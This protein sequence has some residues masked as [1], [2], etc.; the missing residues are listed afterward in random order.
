VISG[1][2]IKMTSAFLKTNGVTLHYHFAT[3]ESVSR[4]VV[5]VNTLGTDFRI[6]QN[7]ADLLPGRPR[8]FYD[9]RGHGQSTS[10]PVTLDLL[11]QDIASLMV[12][13]GLSGA[14]ICGVGLGG[15]VA[16]NLADQMDD[17]VA[18]LVL[19]NSSAKTGDA[20]IWNKR[21]NAVRRGGLE[22]M[23]NYVM[24]QWFSAQF[25]TSQGNRRADMTNVLMPETATDIQD[26]V[27]LANDRNA[28]LRVIGGGKGRLSCGLFPT[29][30]SAN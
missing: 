4:P 2:D 26:A 17:L 27:A 8:L 25:R 3:R 11:T 21:I 20:L 1:L 18:G 29:T 19:C 24:Q 7:L 14:I 10:G 5:F 9:L 28:T 30:W 23:V 22:P 13:L 6:W 12:K 16:Q 15:M